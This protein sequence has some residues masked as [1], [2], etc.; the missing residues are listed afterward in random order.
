MTSLSTEK[1]FWLFV[2]DNYYPGGGMSDFSESYDT[3]SE[4]I[5]LIVKE[6]HLYSNYDLYDSQTRKTLTLYGD[7][8]TNQY[9]FK[10]D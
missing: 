3:V 8:G 10:Y 6:K 2:Y 9:E 7:Q 1:R 4:V 5:E